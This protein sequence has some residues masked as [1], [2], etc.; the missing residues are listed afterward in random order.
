MSLIN[1]QTLLHNWFSINENSNKIT[2]CNET[3]CLRYNIK[4]A[5][6][7]MKTKIKNK[8]ATFSHLTK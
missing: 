8:K 4:R 3:P 7:E 2:L 1:F 5:F 6:T